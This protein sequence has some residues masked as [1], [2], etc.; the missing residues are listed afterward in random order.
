MSIVLG[1]IADD[2]TGATD[3]A[4]ILVQA[5][6][7]TVQIVGMPDENTPV[8][9]AEAVVVALKSRTTNSYD[10]IRMSLIACDWLQKAGAKQIFFKYCSTF[11]STKEG[12]IGPV[13]DA[14]L[15]K[16]GC[17]DT[18][19]CPAF[20]ENGRTVYRGY[21]F[22]NEGLLSESSLR[23]HPLTPMNDP[24][25][26]RVL[27]A[28]SKS[29]ITNIFFEDVEKGPE[30]ISQAMKIRVKSQE[31]TVPVIHIIDALNDNH[32]QSIGQACQ[33]MALITGGSAL[34]QGLP[35]NFR[36]TGWLPNFIKKA[37]FSPPLGSSVILSGSCSEATRAQVEYAK[38]RIPHFRLDAFDILEKKPVV[39]QALE[40][41]EQAMKADDPIM[42]YSSADPE[43]ITRIQKERGRVE[44]GSRVEAVIGKIAHGLKKIGARRFV[45]AGGETSGAVIDALG[46]KTMEIGPP[47]DPGVP[48]TI[49]DGTPSLALALKSGNFGT[50][51]FF[52]KAV[53]QLKKS[54]EIEKERAK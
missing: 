49:S 13:T 1:C 42:F 35:D 27:A 10:A 33:G 22:V 26:K 3:L 6:M 4:M 36:K 47:I 25:L 44:V 19:A 29:H 41:A 18:I 20:P 5:G 2:L 11:D 48:W 21:L 8:P 30:A 45:V 31:K 23:N 28:Q 9:D 50:E 16:L 51:D 24:N 43:I 53:S 52:L 46:V 12:N 40:W 38:S 7:K 34:A 32:L 39:E 15:E 54:D 17:S 14:L 37:S